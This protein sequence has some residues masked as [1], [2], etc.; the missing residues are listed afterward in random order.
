MPE[1]YKIL[2]GGAKAEDVNPTVLGHRAPSPT[3]APADGACQ[4]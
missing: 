3:P 1:E 2:L 4:I